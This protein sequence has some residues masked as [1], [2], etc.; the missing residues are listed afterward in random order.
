MHLESLGFAVPSGLGWRL[1][2]AAPIL[3]ISVVGGRIIPNFTRNWLIKRH[4]TRL[5]APHSAVDR[6]A[7]GV[8]GTGLILW[9]VLPDFRLAG[10]ILVIAAVVNA[11]R[12]ARWAGGRHTGRAAPVHPAC[13]LWLGGD[14]HRASWTFASRHREFRSPRRSTR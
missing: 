5:P 10:V 8:L 2:L 4:S 13:R 14:R 9:A 12:L 11:W 1:G 3:L 6:M 7:V